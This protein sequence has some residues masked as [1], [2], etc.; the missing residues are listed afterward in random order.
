MAASRTL[1]AGVLKWTT[2]I[3]AAISRAILTRNANSN[4]LLLLVN[5]S[6]RSF[7]SMAGG[8]GLRGHDGDYVVLA[9]KL[10]DSGFVLTSRLYIFFLLGCDANLLPRS[11]QFKDL[12]HGRHG[13]GRCIL[14]RCGRA[15]WFDL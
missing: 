13:Q 7:Q 6:V 15:W 10:Q 3:I 1:V 8:K 12:R 2:K 4:Q 14:D 5:D 9:P 11:A